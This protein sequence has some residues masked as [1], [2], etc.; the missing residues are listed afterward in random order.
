M[1][2]SERG[3]SVATWVLALGGAGFAAGFFGPMA[4][5]PGANQGP[6]AGIF[7]T[8]PGGALLGLVMGVAS[9]LL[10]AGL[11][12][13]RQV[14]VTAAAVL[15]LGTLY[16]CLPEPE[17]EG[18][19]IEGSVQTCQL[20]AELEEAAIQDW[21][22]RIEAAPWGQPRDGWREGVDRMLRDA[23]G[24]VLTVD[25]QREDRVLRHRKP[26]NAGRKT[27]AGWTQAN[28]ARRYYAAFA[29][30]DCASYSGPIQILYVRYGQG[31]GVWPPDDAPNFLGVARVEPA[32]AALLALTQ[33]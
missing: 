19:L 1:S 22:R 10:G 27:V 15:S 18:V 2:E 14:L 11:A 20:P 9:R 23:D 7:I 28:E 30:R 24:V 25:V 5:N 21:Q 33:H 3:L 26:W 8:G 12:R 31:S 13:Q 6:M 16:A 17:T 4:L 32:T 29:G